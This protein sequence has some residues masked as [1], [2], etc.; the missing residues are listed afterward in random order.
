M[1]PWAEIYCLLPHER[2]GSGG[3][4]H[5][6]AQGMFRSTRANRGYP[7]TI[8]Q[9]NPTLMKLSRKEVTQGCLTGLLGG[10]LRW[11]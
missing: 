8:A 2:G 9:L 6:R 10:Q 3:Q 1:S 11:S 4:C 5:R 7:I